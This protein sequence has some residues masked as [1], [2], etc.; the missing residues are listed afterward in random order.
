MLHSMTGFATLQIEHSQYA[1]RVELKS[2]NHR[3]L[4]IQFR[5]PEELRSLEFALRNI[6]TQNVSRGKIECKII[7]DKVSMQDNALQVNWDIIDNLAKLG[8][9]ISNK[10]PTLNKLGVADIIRF[11][12]AIEQG[13][14]SQNEDI[15]KIIEQLLQQ[16]LTQFRQDRAREGEKLQQHLSERLDKML[17]EINQLQQI[18]P[19]LLEQYRQ[20]I[21]QRL[22]EVVSDVN[23]D[24]IAQEFTLFVQKADVDEEFSR[25]KTH[26]E[27]VRRIINN[28][29]EQSCGKRLDF[30]MQELNREANTLGSK[31]ISIEST[32][33]SVEL[34]VL[35]EQMR[36]Q[37]QNIE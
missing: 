16:A 24:R 11:P 17:I 23:E 5:L 25:L 10:Y 28:P 36:E 31:A 13:S 15:S 30:L 2:V 4:D 26:I 1:I 8:E 18:F 29:N 27:E 33:T 32:R 19:E 7:I 6:I 22:A 12:L 3:Y 35:I 20:K 37:V 34:K 21:S 14:L 9:Q